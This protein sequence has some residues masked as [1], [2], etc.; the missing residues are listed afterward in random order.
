MKRTPI[1]SLILSELKGIRMEQRKTA[2][3]LEKNT[4][5]KSW[6]AAETAWKSDSLFN[7]RYPIK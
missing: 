1:D 7:A 3:I 6:S 4:D 5:R 2:F